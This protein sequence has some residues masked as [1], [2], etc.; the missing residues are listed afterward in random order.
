MR[1]KKPLIIGAIAIVIGILLLIGAIVFAQPVS[2]HVQD[3]RYTAGEWDKDCKG[4]GKK[5]KCK[6][7]WEPE[8]C[9]ILL[10]GWAGWTE[11]P[12]NEY[13][14]IAVGQYYRG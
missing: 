7:E 6:T 9:E 11:V 14:R 8:V 1:N 10:S 2:G 5:R 3:K 12:C 13:A 4:T